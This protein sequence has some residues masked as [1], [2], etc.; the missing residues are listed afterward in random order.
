MAARARSASPLRS[1]ARCCSGRNAP[2]LPPNYGD[3]LLN[4]P[5]SP[6]SFPTS[7]QS[8][9]LTYPLLLSL[10]CP[11]PHDRHA[12]LLN[13]LSADC[14]A[15]GEGGIFSASPRPAPP[16]QPQTG[17]TL[18]CAAPDAK[19]TEC[20]PCQPR[21]P[22]AAA[23]SAWPDARFEPPEPCPVC[24]LT[25]SQGVQEIQCQFTKCTRLH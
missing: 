6:S 12:P 22:H 16:K 9:K 4:A 20:Q 7:P 3:S 10:N 15:T 13:A 19:W 21:A 11:S 18:G 17:R 2:A 24:P 25:R 1:K 8:A 23:T 14:A 5:N